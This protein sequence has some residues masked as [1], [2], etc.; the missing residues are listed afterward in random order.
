MASRSPL[1]EAASSLLFGLA[2]ALA[3]GLADVY[4]AILGRKIGSFRTTVGMGISGAVVATTAFAIFRPEVAISGRDWIALAVLA[5]V[6]VP[7]LFA[8]Y[9]SLQIGP[10]AIVVPVVTAYA[11]IVVLL[12]LMVLGERLSG[13]QVA[14]VGLAIGGVVFASVDMRRLSAGPRVGL[15]IWLAIASLIGFGF[16]TFVAGFYAQKY[17]W[18]VPSFFVRLTI[19]GLILAI[20][21]ARNQWPWQIASRGWL[22]VLGLTGAVEYVGFLAFVRGAEVGL[23][24][25]VSAASTAYPLVPLIMGI[26]IFGERMAPNQAAGIAAVLVAVVLLATSA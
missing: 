25:I 9:R 12:S 2:A 19:T 4:V 10:V 11:A 7:L 26:V 17:G 3:W 20:A 16:T 14:G 23:V 15:G 1:S 5:I 24:S 8:F 22:A 18:L 13:I 21:A 6:S